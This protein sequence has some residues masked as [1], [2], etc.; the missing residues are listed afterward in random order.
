MQVQAGEEQPEEGWAGLANEALLQVSPLC[1]FEMRC[2]LLR[3][4]DETGVLSEGLISPGNTFGRG[5]GA[6]GRGAVVT[7]KI[8]LGRGRGMTKVRMCVVS[9]R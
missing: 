6:G 7:D 3:R 4:Y 9:G 2:G 8:Q 5:R 1:A